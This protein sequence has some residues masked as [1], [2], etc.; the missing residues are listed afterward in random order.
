MATEPSIVAVC[1][2]CHNLIWEW[3]LKPGGCTRCV[4][5]KLPLRGGV[6]EVCS[7]RVVTKPAKRK[8]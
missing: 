1:P 6:T 5:P 7:P 2:K 8:N 4:P 3:N